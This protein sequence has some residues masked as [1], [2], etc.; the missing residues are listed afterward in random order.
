[1]I[2]TEAFQPPRE[3]RGKRHEPSLVV[4]QM[5][6]GEEG[7]GKREHLIQFLPDQQRNALSSIPYYKKGARKD[8]TYPELFSRIE[9]SWM[10]DEFVPLSEKDRLLYL[11]CF[12]EKKRDSLARKL[13]IS[14]PFYTFEPPF[15]SFLLRDLFTKIFSESAPLPFSFLPEETTSPFLEIGCESFE[16]LFFF[17]G[18]HDLAYEL[19]HLINA[20]IVR[21]LQKALSPTEWEFLQKARQTKHPLF[22][23]NLHIAHWNGDQ[24]LLREVLID[25]GVYRFGKALSKTTPE[26]LWYILHALPKPLAKKIERE[27]IPLQES[28][29]LNELIEQIL[30]TWYTLK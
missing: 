7:A 12:E 23:K 11:S 1:M 8:L 25:R 17:C 21:H 4:L 14:P 30:E 29:L 13:S 18:L 22:L 15:T 2:R 26:T 28:P 19:R 5:L 3:H 20:S 9:E 16:S 6:L 27:L 10:I 24:K